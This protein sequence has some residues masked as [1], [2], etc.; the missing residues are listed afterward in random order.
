[1]RERAVVKESKLQHSSERRTSN[2]NLFCFDHKK[3]RTEGGATPLK[4]RNHTTEK[5]EPHHAKEGI[6]YKVVTTHAGV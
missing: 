6:I 3:E 2:E 1:M 4:G 5:G